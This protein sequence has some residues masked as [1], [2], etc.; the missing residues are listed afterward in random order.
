MKLKMLGGL[1]AALGMV[2]VFVPAQARGGQSAAPAGTAEG[3]LAWH[4]CKGPV[5]NCKGPNDAMAG[6]KEATGEWSEEG[7]AKLF[8]LQDCQRQLGGDRQLWL[9]EDDSKLKCNTKKSAAPQGE[10]ERQEVVEGS[11]A[12]ECEVALTCMVGDAY[13]HTCS[14]VRYPVSAGSQSQ[15]EGKALEETTKDCRKQAKGK[16]YPKV[17]VRTDFL[18]C[19]A[20]K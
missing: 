10:A 9:C 15:A 6:C 1:L 11:L 14:Y 20:K 3:P 17:Y 13:V 8:A 4:V 7:T 16:G 12:W 18:M 19:T 2:F 5:N